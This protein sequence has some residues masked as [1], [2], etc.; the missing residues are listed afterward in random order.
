MLKFVNPEGNYAPPGGGYTQTVTVPANARWL[1][2]AGQVGLEYFH[3]DPL[4][5]NFSA[6]TDIM[7]SAYA[8]RFRILPVSVNT[9]EAVI[10]TAEPYVKDWEKELAPILRLDIRRVIANP[11][12]IARYQVEFYNL[13]KSIKGAERS[14]DKRSGLGNFEQLVEMG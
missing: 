7:S 12:D 10:A 1:V 4:K 6:V 13:A 5:I 2:L 9:R 3:I 11:L 8:S 14:G